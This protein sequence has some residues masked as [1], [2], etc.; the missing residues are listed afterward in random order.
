[1][2]DF[3]DLSALNKWPEHPCLEL[4]REAA[5][6]T[7]LGTIP[8]VWAD[9]QAALMWLRVAFDRFIELSKRVSSTCLISVE[10]NHYSVPVSFANRPV[11]LRI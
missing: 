5:D 2:P 10:C 6:G 11:S 8:D 9:K 3:P 7:L 4:W 1:M